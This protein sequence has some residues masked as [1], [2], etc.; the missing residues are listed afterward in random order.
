MNTHDI[1]EI[2]RGTLLILEL[3]VLVIANELGVSVPPV[4]IDSQVHLRPV[5]L[6]YARKLASPQSNSYSASMPWLHEESPPSI[7]D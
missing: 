7:C 6:F 5:A 1:V 3:L 4:R 2:V